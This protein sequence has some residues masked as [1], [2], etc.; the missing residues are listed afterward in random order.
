[1]NILQLVKYYDPCQGGM[2]TVVKNIAEGVIEISD[3]VNFTILSNNHE[4]TQSKIQ[5]KKSDRLYVIKEF[6]PLLFRS[7]PLCFYYPSLKK[8]I[9]DS[10]IIHHHYPFPTMEVSL[11]L[12]LNLIREKKFIITWHANIKNS[13]W[14]WIEKFYN[15]LISKLLDRADAIVVTSPQLFEASDILKKYSDK[16]K[17]IP[18][19]FNPKLAF[20]KSKQFPKEKPFELLFVGKLRK[21][22]GI[23]FLITAIVDL[24]INLTIVGSGEEYQS[25]LSKVQELNISEKVNFIINASDKELA[26][27]YA[28]ADLFI[29]PSI[30]EA[31]AFGVVQL[32]AMS[33]GLP[34]I[35]TNLK[36]GVPF[37]SLNNYTGFTVE[38]K[39]SI[40][41][42]IAI[43]KIISNKELYEQFS[44]NAL[45][46]VNLFTREKMSYTYFD[47]YK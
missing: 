33:N 22:K 32:E 36:S 19:S 11:L 40:H 46:R 41:L 16:I 20:A 2:E 23:K 30:N 45:E 25:L 47:L 3:D 1:M 28:S 39:N 14:N 5:I 10:D 34:V 6:T 12:F 27:L 44:L 37:V 15:P 42:K 43:Q 29:L 18:L 9:K 13:R 7:Q 26:S 35:N 4:I 17:V 21:Y 24:N 31:E 38:P 8:L